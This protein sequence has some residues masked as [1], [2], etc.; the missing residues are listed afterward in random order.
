[1]KRQDDLEQIS[2]A[3]PFLRGILAFLLYLRFG[4]TD[5]NYHQVADQFIAQLKTDLSK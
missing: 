5:Q 2:E 1:M 3:E 4:P